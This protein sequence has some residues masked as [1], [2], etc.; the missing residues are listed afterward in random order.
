MKSGGKKQMEEYMRIT[1]ASEG[2]IEIREISY[3]HTGE[4]GLETTGPAQISDSFL[5]YAVNVE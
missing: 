3:K 2:G 4:K 5:V 1:Y